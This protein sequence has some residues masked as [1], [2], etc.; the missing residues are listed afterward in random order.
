MKKIDFLE[1]LDLPTKKRAFF[2]FWRKW[3][4][5]KIKKKLIKISTGGVCP[6]YYYLPSAQI[7]EMTVN[8]ELRFSKG[9]VTFSGFIVDGTTTKVSTGTKFEEKLL[10]SM[11]KIKGLG[12][13]FEY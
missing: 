8:R 11:L 1:K 5:K 3:K 2:K 13:L 10:S 6:H 4:K 9:A 12:I 7:Q